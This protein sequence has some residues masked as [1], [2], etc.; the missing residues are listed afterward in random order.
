VHLTA[1]EF[2]DVADGTRSEA[3]LP[4]LAVCESCRA[5]LAAMRATIASASASES[6]V[7]EPS[8][9]FWDQFSAR[10]RKTIDADVAGRRWWTA[11]IAPRVLVP[12]TA[13]AGLILVVA[14]IPASRTARREMPQ[15]T[16]TTAADASGSAGPA[17]SRDATD[18][19]A[20]PLLAMVADLSANMD[21]DS[22]VAAGFTGQGSADRV[23]S[24]MNDA[25]LRT[26]KRLLQDELARPGA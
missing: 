18:A 16:S 14:L 20:D 8:P 3:S 17:E 23:V 7:P 10:V 4:H 21:L 12:L 19:A 5:Q 11:W 15:S 9:M 1:D 6:D 22:A 24:R 13:V 25:E 26:L 2:V